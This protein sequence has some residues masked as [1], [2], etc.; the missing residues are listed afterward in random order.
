MIGIINSQQTNVFIPSITS[1]SIKDITF[2]IAREQFFHILDRGL[3]LFD[4]HPDQNYIVFFYDDSRTF[5]AILFKSQS[6]YIGELC[7][8]GADRQG[9]IIE[10]YGLYMMF[11]RMSYKQGQFVNNALH[12]QGTINLYHGYSIL[13][14]TFVNGKCTGYGEY[15]QGDGT[16]YKGDY[17]DN[18]RHGKGV[19]YYGKKGTYTGEF[20][21]NVYHGEGMIENGQY[22]CVR[23]TFQYH[24]LLHGTAEYKD[25]G[26]YVGQFSNLL[27]HGHGKLSFQILDEKNIY[28][29]TYEGQFLNG[30]RHGYGVFKNPA[31][32]M[33]FSGTFEYNK[34]I[35]G[36]LRFGLHRYL[37]NV[38]DMFDANGQ[39]IIDFNYY[40]QIGQQITLKSGKLHFLTAQDKP[41]YVGQ[42]QNNLRHGVG[43]LRDI[44]GDT[45]SGDWANNVRHGKGT[46]TFATGGH[47]NGYWNNNVNEEFDKIRAARR[48]VQTALNISPREIQVQTMMSIQNLLK[49]MTKSYIS[50]TPQGAAQVRQKP[51]IVLK[52]GLQPSWS[53]EQK[54]S[55]HLPS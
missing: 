1:T 38:N 27:P 5:G 18:N 31:R 17:V 48:E 34:P 51:R 54:R 25:G 10:G 14:G 21:D 13:N 7:R 49:S 46:F 42:I 23:G 50:N 2:D 20:R 43:T 16:W 24:Y 22:K 8:G 9:V 3:E 15:T 6:F 36:T 45:Y 30:K 26:I 11:D 53:I 35:N 55:L 47:Y 32:Q 28:N 37:C 39:G 33:E 19:F 29:C 41:Q 4:K 52:K 40:A 12:G 44:S